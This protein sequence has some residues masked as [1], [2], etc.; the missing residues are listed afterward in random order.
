MKTTIKETCIS[1]G[2]KYFTAIFISLTF[3]RGSYL[4]AQNTSYD[5][6]NIPI[7]TG[8]NC[9]VFGG[10]ALL[11]NIGTDNTAI[12]YYT[13]QNNI[14]GS[15]NTAVGSTALQASNSYFNTAIGQQCMAFNTTGDNNT[16]LGFQALLL[17]NSGQNNTATGVTALN[18]STG[19]NNTSFGANSLLTLTSGND[20]TALGFMADVGSSAVSN[21]MALGN[22]AVVNA[23][24]RIYLGDAS[25]TDIQGAVLFTTSDGRFKTDIKEGDIRGL[26]F[27]KLLRPVAYNFESKKFTEFLCKNMTPEVRQK[28]LDKDFSAATKIRQSGF[29]AQEVEIAANKAGYDF[30][31]VHK[32]VDDNDN[33]SLAYGQFVVPLVKGMQEQQQ[34]IE[35]Q[36]QRIDALEKNNAELMKKISASTG[37]GHLSEISDGFTMEQNI[38][39]PFNQKTLITYN[40][41]LTFNSAYIAVYD[42]A[43][44]QLTTQQLTQKGASSVVISSEKLAAGIY[45]YSIIADGKVMDSKRMIIADK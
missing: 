18:N 42:L 37:I 28:H 36:K 4:Q 32:P 3:C 29:I 11:V 24:N 20:L 12:G 25:I 39:N 23:S 17:N 30:N 44:K 35:Q 33:Y 27:I 43:G 8:N 38:P 13:L 21:A 26:E 15:S 16:A 22:G 14:V 2:A 31:G 6:N 10:S 40:L 9:A 5:A 45:I 19:N 41:P 34:M 1:Q 7:T